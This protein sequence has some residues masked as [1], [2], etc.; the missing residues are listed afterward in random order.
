MITAIA[1]LAAGAAAC[2]QSVTGARNSGEMSLSFAAVR[3]AAGSAPQASGAVIAGDSINVGG[4]T[5]DVMSVELTARKI[6]ITGDDDVKTELKGGPVVIALPVDGK[7]VTAVKIPLRAG[8]YDELEMKIE[9]VRIKGTFDG[10]AFDATV[11]VVAEIEQSINPPL[12]VAENDTSNLTVAL[13]VKTWFVTNQGTVID[14]RDMSPSVQA[15]LMSNIKASLH[16][17]DDDDRD[18]HDD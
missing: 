8:T 13:D 3:P 2:D 1:A 15:Q 12:T 17:F 16:A 4:H 7:L 10:Q 5:I 11:R 14:P 9:S 6:E 18:G